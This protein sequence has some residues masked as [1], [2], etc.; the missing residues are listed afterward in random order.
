[1]KGEHR[2]LARAARVWFWSVVVCA[3]VVIGGVVWWGRGFTEVQEPQRALECALMEAPPP[4]AEAP[5]RS[6]AVPDPV[7]ESWVSEEELTDHNE[8]EPE[9]C[10]E[11]VLHDTT[12]P[13][14]LSDSPFDDTSLND[15]IG[16]GGGAGG[17]YAKRFSA[18]RPEAQNPPPST[19]TSA[20]RVIGSRGGDDSGEVYESYASPG[21]LAVIDN[22]L[23]TF[24]I[25]V[26][27]ASYTN[28]R[29]MLDK[30][31][32]PPP[33]AVRVEEFVNQFD[34]DYERPGSD[35]P[36]A[37][38]VEVA[39][40]PWRAENRLV[41]VA[42]SSHGTEGATR[43]PR[44]LVFLIDVSGS[45]KDADKLPL[46]KRGLR[47]LVNDLDERDSLSIVT[48]ASGTRVALEPTRGD[49][50]AEILAVLDELSAEGSTNGSGGLQLAY[51]RASKS[52]LEEGVNRVL[53]GTDGDFN[54]GIQSKSELV[55]FIVEK[56]KS[57]VFLTVLGFGEGNLKDRNLEQ[58]A[59]KGNG[60]YL[61]VDSLQ[62]A[63]RVF[64][65]EVS[66]NLVTVAKDVKLQVEF[67]PAEV[68]SYRLVGYANRALTAR[69]FNDDRVDA[70]EIGAGHEVTAFYEVV[71]TRAGSALGVDP[72]RYQKP[73]FSATEHSGSGELLTVKLRYK[74]PAEPESRR[75]VQRARDGGA[76][77]AEASTDFRFATAVALFGEILA[78]SP[79][80]EGSGLSDVLALLDDEVLQ[81]SPEQR[82]EFFDLVMRAK[83]LAA[84]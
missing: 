60:H 64:V 59:N 71:P 55:D 84:N 25:D 65:D 7:E 17:M 52:F 76:L 77:F 75:F 44:N 83:E 43:R 30:G 4:L 26:D 62:E 63:R 81:D 24:S 16:F 33:A 27:R 5:E 15:V 36:L 80:S 9:E 46:F 20:K 19:R 78:G 2:R 58:I 11:P 67:N 3:T 29:R 37:V 47:L 12:S 54:V 8:R 40:C 35:E 69:E 79:H 28:V 57:G 18:P 70:G 53:L 72:L 39:T 23:S 32:L 50:K 73:E 38:D 10:E 6:E 42:L 41:R 22:P 51:E 49:R 34:Y 82:T 74:L 45:M 66:R 21:F 61:Y 14:F 13:D 31:V 68:A 1:M 56:A 48:Y